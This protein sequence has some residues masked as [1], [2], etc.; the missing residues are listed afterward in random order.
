MAGGGVQCPRELSVAQLAELLQREFGALSSF[1]ESAAAEIV[2]KASQPS[3][4][5]FD[6]SRVAYRAQ[7]DLC[8]ALLEARRRVCAAF[9]SASTALSD[10]AAR[11][12]AGRRVRQLV[13]SDY[14]STLQP[15]LSSAVVAQL[16]FHGAE[17]QDIIRR[18]LALGGAFSDAVSQFTVTHLVCSP[19]KVGGAQARTAASWG[20]RL[21][22]SQWLSASAAEG[23]FLDPAAFT[24]AAADPP[25]D[26]ESPSTPPP[27][28][29]PS[30]GLAQGG[31]RGLTELRDLIAA[32]PGYSAAGS[33]AALSQ[34]AASAPTAELAGSQRPRISRKELGI[35]DG[36]M[37]PPPR[38]R[39]RTGETVSRWELDEADTTPLSEKPAAAFPAPREQVPLSAT[40][41]LSQ[42]VRWDHTAAN[43]EPRDTAGGGAPSGSCGMAIQI[44]ASQQERQEKDRIVAICKRL[45]A[46]L[47]LAPRY[48]PSATHL[49]ALPGAQHRTEKYLSFVAAGKWILTPSFVL[50]SDEAGRWLHPSD[51]GVG[52][53][54]QRL[55]ERA[56]RPFAEWRVVLHAEQRIRNGLR[57]IL[58]A[59][60]CADVSAPSATTLRSAT[61]LLCDIPDG[62]VL[63][64]P[65]DGADSS[66]A[67]E[68]GE[69]CAVLSIEFLYQFLCDESTSEAEHL[70]RWAVSLTPRWAEPA[71]GR[72]GAPQPPADGVRPP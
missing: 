28:A 2:S 13:R 67:P 46:E 21:V 5:T 3:C 44:A 16:G 52:G 43:G 61:H 29:P 9:D 50:D 31:Y 32:D 17:K 37:G 38:K 33:L 7:G 60:G 18:V 72:E 48:C 47:L 14:T 27:P 8:H 58:E 53:R 62:G 56:Q 70:T 22:S 11:G 25:T 63:H 66:R 20:I 15:G 65:R 40:E 23:R 49:V 26:S 36:A 57:T 30:S 68:L 71:P 64:V 1:A 41:Q 69:G 34:I 24:L 51:F 59:G 6:V 39:P 4:T 42:V 54:A 55:R 35:D 45:G 10:S 19:H 12:E